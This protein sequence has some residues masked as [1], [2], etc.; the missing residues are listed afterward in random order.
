MITAASA[1]LL[2]YLAGAWTFAGVAA[3]AGGSPATAVRAV[4]TLP[5]LALMI[6]CASAFGAATFCA[7]GDAAARPLAVAII[8]LPWILISI[9]AI[10]A[11]DASSFTIVR[12]ASLPAPPLMVTPGVRDVGRLMI[13][14]GVA[15][16][17]A[18][19]ASERRV[20]RL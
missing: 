2:S 6:F 9:F 3:A 16:A 7:V 18:A 8:V 13:Y 20:A 10:S 19:A 4:A 15:F 5:L 17:L 11:G 14:A 1:S 12:I